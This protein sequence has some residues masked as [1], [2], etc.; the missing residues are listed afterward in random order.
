MS[1]A[2]ENLKEQYKELLQ[3]TKV[4][5]F[6]SWTAEVNWRFVIGFYAIGVKE[7][8]SNCYGV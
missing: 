1:P 3:D 6:K 8:I 2:T 4:H 5:K 7:V